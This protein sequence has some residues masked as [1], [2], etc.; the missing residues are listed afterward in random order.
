MIMTP[1][2]VLTFCG[3]LINVVVIGLQQ[4]IKADIAELRASIAERYVS[5]SDMRYMLAQHIKASE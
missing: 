3:I 1:E 2:N 5:K 4:K